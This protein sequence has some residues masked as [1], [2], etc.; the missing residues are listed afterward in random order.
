MKSAGIGAYFQR[1]HD[2]RLSFFGRNSSSASTRFER[3]AL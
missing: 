2:S 1:F 3:G